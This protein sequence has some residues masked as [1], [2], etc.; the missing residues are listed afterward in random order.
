MNEGLVNT[1]YKKY[2]TRTRFNQHQKPDVIRY[3]THAPFLSSI[4]DFSFHCGEN[5]RIDKSKYPKLTRLY[6][7][8]E[9]PPAHGIPRSPI[10]CT[11][12]QYSIRPTVVSCTISHK[13]SSCCPCDV[14]SDVN[15]RTTLP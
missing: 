1:G 3:S 2:R 7:I 5:E 6:M 13:Q 9:E 14:K 15:Q 11:S 8:P 10:T 12:E 4:V